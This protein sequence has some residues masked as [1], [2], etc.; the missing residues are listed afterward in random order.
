M[1][2]DAH[3]FPPVCLASGSPR[4][5]ELLA[6]LG[7]LFEVHPVTLDETPVAGEAPLAYVKRLACQKA[8]IAHA[9]FEGRF[10]VVIGADT[11][12]IHKKRIFGKPK[13][14]QEAQAMLAA[15]SGEVHE[16]YSAIAI[17]GRA[18]L[19]VAVSKTKVKFRVLRDEEIQRYWETGEPQDKAGAYAI[20]GF[21]ASFIQEIQGSYSGVMG[22]PL[23][24]TSRLL[25][26]QGVPLWNQE[27]VC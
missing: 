16:T 26:V 14:Q 2:H 12:V 4:R 9:M 23:Y 15:L 19:Q 8:R 25:N 17:T 21:A 5:R 18:G 20:Q 27:T 1:L 24:E 6:Q 22:L 7:V 13:D 11:A 3:E 10:P